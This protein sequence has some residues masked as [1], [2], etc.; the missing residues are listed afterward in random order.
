MKLQDIGESKD[1][2]EAVTLTEVE[3]VLYGLAAYFK[4][5][6]EQGLSE[7]EAI[8][9]AR[10]A[11]SIQ[12]DRVTYMGGSYSLQIRVADYYRFVNKGVNGLKKDWGSPYS[13][14]NMGVSTGMLSSIRKWVIREGLKVRTNEALKNPV[15]QERKGKPFSGLKGDAAA[16]TAF[17]VSRGI[18]KNGLKPT[19]FWD[20]ALGEVEKRMKQDLRSVL[21]PVVVSELK[22]K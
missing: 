12:W 11:E 22:R 19:F 8:S 13:F 9:S 18:K 10:L 6:A 14:R 1:S 5:T 15:G 16:R 3:R 17:V 21:L 20:N 2:L 4:M 7:A